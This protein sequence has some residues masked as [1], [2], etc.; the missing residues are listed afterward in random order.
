[1]AEAPADLRAYAA[2]AAQIR[3]EC[4]GVM[5]GA[6]PHVKGEKLNQASMAML[7][8]VLSATFGAAE[9]LEHPADERFTRTVRRLHWSNPKLTKLLHSLALEQDEQAAS[10][11]PDLCPD[12]KFWVASGYTTLSPGT[13]RFLHRQRVVSSITTIEPEP[14]ESPINFFDLD[15]LVKHRLKP[16]ED[17]ADQLLARRAFPHEV[18]LTNP[19]VRPFLEAIGAIYEALGRVTPASG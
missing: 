18:K 1:V 7:D 16:Y 9:H 2:L 4:P 5:T 8:E 17:H 12:L 3:A 15:A 10:P 14:H 11:A 19:R 13:K 6:P